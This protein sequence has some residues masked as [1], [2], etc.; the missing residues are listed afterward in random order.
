MKR[1]LAFLFILWIPATAISAQ[2][3]NLEEEVRSIAAGLRCVVCQNLS[4][5]DSPSEM[6]QQMRGIIRDQLQEGKSPE[7]INAYFVS[8]YGEWVLLA[9][10]A[11]GFSLL[12]WVLPFIA[13]I[14][15]IVF[16]MFV[17]RRWVRKKHGSTSMAVDQTLI[18]RVRQEVAEGK[19]PQVEEEGP[20]APLLQEQA[21]LYTD[22]RELEFDFQA[23]KL[24][25]VDYQYLRRELEMQAAAALKQIES[26]SPRH[27]G[28][29]GPT[30]RQK[31]TQAEKKS[32]ETAKASRR[33][34]QIAVGGAFLL[35]FRG[36]R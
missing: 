8:K 10:T 35:L 33:G 5:A 25:E 18:E 17:A 28:A 30:S 7:Q 22:L 32:T 13:L 36:C 24:S 16:V 34:W 12:L 23:E 9:P 21:R 3:A 4:V 26:L 29:P 11:K 19:S 15:G 31:R 14:A 6:A 1:F 27:S 2:P 20:N